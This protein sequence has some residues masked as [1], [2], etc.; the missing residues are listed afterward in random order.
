[1]SIAK[2]FRLLG[3]L[4]VA[5]ACPV[6]GQ[7]EVKVSS[8]VYVPTL[9]VDTRLVEIAAVVRDGHG[10]AV[11]GLTKDDFRVLD[12]GKERLIDHFVVDNAPSETLNEH[13]SGSAAEALKSGISAK[14][15]FLALFIDDVNATDGALANGLKLT[16]AAA[17][18]FIKGALKGDTKIG[19]FTASG[20][21]TVEFTTDEAKLIEA[22]SALK[23]HVKMKEDGLAHCPRVTPYF[24]FRIAYDKDQSVIRAVQFDAS[25]KDCVA[26]QS[27]IIAQAEETWRQVNG[28]T[29]DTLNAIGR[30]VVYLGTMPGRRELL[31]ASS[32]FL[33]GPNQE[34]KNK[35]VDRAL[36][37]DVVINALDAKGI[38]SE[39]QPGVRPQ[40]QG[41]TESLSG[42]TAA[43]NQWIRFETL[44]MPLR[45]QALSEPMEMLAEGTGGVFFHN[46][47]DLNAGFRETGGLP[48]VTY[49]LSFR[50]ED[51]TD[52]AY[53]KLKLSVIH[54]KNYSV[55][56]RPGY[57]APTDKTPESL[58]ARID[59]EIVAEDTKSELPVGMAIRQVEATLAVTLHVD[60]S[61][62]RFEKKGDREAQRI[63][64]AVALM[65]AQGRIVIA[66]EGEM[67]LALTEGNYKGLLGSGVKAIIHLQAPAGSYKLRQVTEEAIE[68]KI[69]C[70]TQVVEVK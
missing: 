44:E 61:K 60:I 8:G 42:S 64:F 16:Q 56:A 11:P 19:V 27:M 47:N 21:Q 35:I 14:P 4:C 62:L 34:L 30:L 66:K 53:H 55:Q 2:Q 48:E 70:S 29:V 10:K 57:F 39:A 18:K 13:K 6:E 41:F 45:L 33:A 50:P 46:N 9:R 69:A 36:R 3:L 1:L 49:R 25:Q 32:G 26:S 12:D 23:A 63:M 68:G 22:I 51:A 54:T 17:K 52:G 15:R 43:A 24:A 65:D 20:A 67:D 58:Q 31:L 38:Y 59:R 37:S 28:I 5:A 40:D 7:D